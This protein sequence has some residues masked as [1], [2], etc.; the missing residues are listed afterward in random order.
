MR[1]PLQLAA[2]LLLNQ[3]WASS[4]LA[5][6]CTV[7]SSV[8][9]FGS[10]NP[11]TDNTVESTGTISVTCSESVFYTLSLSPGNSGSYSTRSMINSGNYLEYNL[12]I[13]AGYSQIWG[14]GT[15]GSY[16]VNGLFPAE[17]TENHTI[18]GIIPLFNQRDASV[19]VYSDTIAVTLTY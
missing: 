13:D 8:L 4:T 10:F 14:D 15:G 17:G 11:L 3:L 7:D 18:Y 5:S 9:S 1:K 2:L 16:T 19:G 6:T 12:F